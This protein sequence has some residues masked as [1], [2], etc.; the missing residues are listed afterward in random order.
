MHSVRKHKTEAMLPQSGSLKPKF[1]PISLAIFVILAAFVTLFSEQ[2][3]HQL[4]EQ[5]S[6]DIAQNAL[7]SQ[8]F[9]SHILQDKLDHFEQTTRLLANT[10]NLAAYASTAD[11]TTRQ[12]IENLWITQAEHWK[13]FVQVRFLDLQGQEHIRVNYDSSKQQAKIAQQL[14]FKGHRPY[15]LHAATLK[16]GEIGLSVFD[17]EREHNQY[18]KPYLIAARM[19]TPVVNQQG[20]RAGYLV[21]N[22]N[23]AELLADFNHHQAITDLDLDILTMSGHYIYEESAEITFGHVVP[24]RSHW[25]LKQTEQQLWQAIEGGNGNG[26]H[27]GDSQHAAFSVLEI[28]P[29]DNTKLASPHKFLLLTR[30]NRDKAIAGIQHALATIDLMRIIKLVILIIVSLGLGLLLQKLQTKQNA[31]SLMLSA[32]NGMAAALMLD[33]NRTIVATNRKFSQLMGYKSKE[34]LGKSPQLIRSGLHSSDEI[35]AIWQQLADSGQW[36]GEM[37]YRCKSGELITT[38]QEVTAIYWNKKSDYPDFY[39]ASFIDISKQKRLE[40]QLR[41]QS[42]T[43]WLTGVYN[44]RRFDDELSRLIND[45][46]RYPASSFSLALLDIDLFKKINDSLGHNAGDQVLVH[47]AKQVSSMLRN[48]DF[49]GRVG[50]EEFAVLLPFT[51]AEDAYI[52]M[53]RIRLCVAI[54]MKQPPITCSI[55][56]VEFKQ[57]MTVEGIYKAA[58]SALYQAKSTGRNNSVIYQDSANSQLAE[59]TG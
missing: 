12:Q 15:F 48:T 25:S 57:G 44:R 55:G 39:I 13:T 18:V 1:W 45:C 10:E 28:Q 47:F 41:K 50:G 46:T 35:R 33:Q 29:D 16:Q 49:I 7:I 54:A 31:K 51:S 53:E 2:Q 36:Q 3:K 58:D 38:W 43:D 20:A 4:I 59:Q 22:L 5:Q 52:V 14:Q 32:T 30:F 27:F 34:A 6:L 11:A 26:M 24:E 40:Q 42:V 23:I 37:V 56:I 17:L 19:I 8:Q 9:L 21:V